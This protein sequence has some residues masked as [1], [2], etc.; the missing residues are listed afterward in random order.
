MLLMGPKRART[1]MMKAR[2]P[3]QGISPCV[4]LRPPMTI[5]TTTSTPEMSSITT[6]ATRS[7]WMRAIIAS[8]KALPFSTLSRACASSAWKTL[9]T[10]MPRSTWRM[11]SER[12]KLVLR[13]A[14]ERFSVR[15]AMT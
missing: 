1:A 11:M 3:A 5:T 12:R 2:R 13:T 4:T 8:W 14:N 6:L 15:L 7:T 9:M 10:R